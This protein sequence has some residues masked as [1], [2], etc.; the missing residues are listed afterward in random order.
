MTPILTHNIA[1]LP[2]FQDGF[3]LGRDTGLRLALDQL[4]AERKRQEAMLAR[5]YPSSIR[6]ARIS[7]CEASLRE[8]SKTVAAIFRTGQETR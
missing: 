3:A 2:L 7:Y 1:A 4:T 5:G 6:Y 8:V